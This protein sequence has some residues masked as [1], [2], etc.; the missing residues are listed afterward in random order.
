MNTWT[1]T[2]EAKAVTLDDLKGTCRRISVMAEACG[3]KHPAA[4]I[5]TPDYLRAF[6]VYCDG[7][8]S[9]AKI[10]F[11]GA[12]V[13]VANTMDEARKKAAVFRLRRGL[14]ADILYCGY[15]DAEGE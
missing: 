9:P 4:V 6:R 13:F 2:S 7:M 1:S 8:S 14:D 5:M 11:A 10:M 12:T 15:P 3:A